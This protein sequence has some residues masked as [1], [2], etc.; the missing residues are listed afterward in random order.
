MGS[1]VRERVPLFV[2]SEDVM[3]PID[4]FGTDH[5]PFH[6]VDGFGDGLTVR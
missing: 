6:S 5:Q 1:A 2:C 3:S 4:R